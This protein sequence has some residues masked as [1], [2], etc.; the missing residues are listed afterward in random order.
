MTQTIRAL[1]VDD[2][3][4]ARQG[5]RVRLEREPDIE[6]IGEAEDGPSAVDAILRLRPDLLF[7]DIQMPG[8]DGFEVL[9]RVAHTYVP[10]VVFVTAYDQ[11]AL[12]AFAVHALDYL[13]KP[14]AHRRFKESLR[15]ARTQLARHDEPAAVER[16]RGLVEERE[17][18]PERSA[19][20]V[21]FTV[22]DGDRFILLRTADIDWIESAANYLRLHVGA[23]AYQLRMTMAEVEGKLD[24]HQFARIHRSAVVNL[25]RVASINPNWQGEYDVLL[26]S[27]VR[28]R[29]SRSYR[30]R[31]L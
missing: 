10:T 1:I 17:A 25:D 8:F 31:L 12:R 11:H 21:R 6:V 13:L 29:L 22:R 19:F 7:L 24:P 16:L 5:I 26:T 9:A 30:D 20:A 28:L 23:K 18:P 2:E 4:L 3:P 14:I 27:G 15:R